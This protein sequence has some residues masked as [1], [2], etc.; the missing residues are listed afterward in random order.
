MLE[1]KNLTKIY[2]TKGG[3]V[4]AL[5]NV[6]VS[7]DKTGLIFLLGKSG[8]GKSTLLNLIGGLDSPTEGE[9]IVFNKSSKDFSGSDFDSYRNTYV[10]FIFQ[11]YNILNEFNVEDNIALALE[12]QGKRKDKHKIAA[13]L[14]EVELSDYAKRKPNTLSGGQKQRI[15]IARALVKDPQIIMA[16]EPTGALDSATGK[17]VFDTLKRLSKTRLVLV[18]SHD[19][20]F[21]SLYGD[22]IIELSD[23][24]IISDVSKIKEEAQHIAPSIVKL[25]EDTITIKGGTS[26]DN[27]SLQKIESFIRSSDGD[28]IISKGKDDIAAFKRIN[29]IDEYGARERFSATPPQTQK[30]TE[31]AKFIR[32]KL[33][34]S[35]AIKIGASGLRLKPFRLVLTILLSI[36]S[37]V[38]FGL[39]STMMLYSETAVLTK[40]YFNSD[41]TYITIKK[42]YEERYRNTYNDDVY[43]ELYSTK[44]TRDEVNQFGENAF[45]TYTFPI[46]NPSNVSIAGQNKTYYVPNITKLTALSSTHPLRQNIIGKYPVA[47]N[48]V[49]VSSYFLEC[50]KVATFRD[51]SLG[52]LGDKVEINTAEDLIG[53]Y[54]DIYSVPIKITGIFDSG[55][56]PTTYDKLKEESYETDVN[57]YIY[58][59]Y[60][61]EGLHSLA[62]VSELFMNEIGADFLYNNAHI[63]DYFD[64]S[65]QYFYGN[66]TIPSGYTKNILST[67]NLKLYSPSA[68]LPIVFFRDG[69]TNLSGN[70][71]VVSFDHIQTY[72]SSRV[73]DIRN[74]WGDYTTE[75]REKEKAEYNEVID[76]F[77]LLTNEYAYNNGKSYRPTSAQRAEAAQKVLPYIKSRLPAL[78]LESIKHGD[79]DRIGLG[80][81]EIVGAYIPD[82]VAGG[83]KKGFYCSEELYNSV[84]INSLASESNYKLEDGAVYDN[85]LTPLI[86]NESNFKGLL[87]K[88]NVRSSNDVVYSLDNLLKQKV[89][90]ANATVKALSKV[91]LWIGLVLALFASLMLFNFISLS[92][93]NKKRDI[94]ILRAVGARGIDVFKIFFSESAII[95]GICAFLSLVGTF[96]LSNILNTVLKADVGFEVTLFVF[97]PLPAIVM[98]VVA[99]FVAFISTF[100]P[101]YFAARKKPVD[102]IRAL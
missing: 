28:I 66:V 25:G 4:K 78:T 17:Q 34:L 30:Q 93:S 10:G 37:F 65:E 102:S 8:S 23:G 75:E 59:F 45:G 50:M 1:I 15:A 35:K 74:G 89:D 9:V 51:Y 57:A 97:G 99:L 83:I 54:L 41:Y 13:I 92:I 84:D 44:F 62:L 68:R 69:V 91:F 18:V 19:R 49:A 5:D 81:F 70:Q 47:P 71:I 90:Q 52:V 94:G 73:S 67:N 61:S 72:M 20:E 26:L 14:S 22:R 87:S 85:I 95:V 33:P 48:E 100:L 40:S 53:Q 39:F 77:S 32:S 16:D 46:L 80:E 55:E 27:E 60:L 43:S 24:K 36:F 21:A 88:F 64:T 56:I 7:F 3:D 6:S 2:K 11:E 12:L 96:V 82:F 79:A 76:Y 98:L 29:R 63:I 58:Q 38:M 31:Q 42:Q 86:K 101:V